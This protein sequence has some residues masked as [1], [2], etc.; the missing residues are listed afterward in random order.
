MG[1]L[2][3]GSVLTIIFA[4]Q[5]FGIQWYLTIIAIAL[6]AVLSAVAVRSVGE[7]DINP[8]GGMGKVT[9]LVFGGLS[10]GMMSTNLMSAAITSAGASQAAD[11]MQDLKTGSLLGA[12]PR[13]QFLAQLVGICAGVVFVVPVFYIFSMAYEFGGEE[14][15]APAAMAWKAMAELLAAGFGALPPQAPTAVLLAALFGI[16]ITLLRRVES[17]KNYVPSGLAMGIAFIIPAYYSFVMFYGLIAWFIWRRV[18]PQAA[19]KL[20]FAVASGLI[21]GEGLMGIVNAVLTLLG[22]TA[23]T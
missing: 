23:V 8:I 20:N 19:D 14:M 2:A 22:I 17:I 1:G 5:L 3:C 4:Q 15:P 12:A 7:T 10:P 9:Q 13:K 18:N 6:S 11:M 21:A 16:A